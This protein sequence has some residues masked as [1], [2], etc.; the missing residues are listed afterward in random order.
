MTGIGSYT[1]NS[2]GRM[3]GL[4]GF[5]T[6]TTIKSLMDAEKLPL[7]LLQQ[8]RQVVEWRQEAYRDVTTSLRGFK[9]T[10]FDV[11]NPATNMLS[12]TSIRTLSAASSSASYVTAIAASDADLASHT[13]R[14]NKLAT[15]DNALSSSQITK[16]LSGTVSSLNL[17]GKT[18]KATLDGV[19]REITLGDYTGQNIGD[20]LKAAME[21]AFGAGKIAVAYDAGNS[22]GGTI[23]FTTTGGAGKL[24]LSAG[25]VSGLSELGITSGTANRININQSLETISAQLGTAM[26]FNGDYANITINGKAFSFSKS[27]SLASAMSTINADT[28]ANVRIAYDETSD[29]L[30]IKS[31]QLGAGDNI[32]L[33]ESSSTFFS[34]LKIDISGSQTGWAQGQDSEAEIDGQL[35][36]RNS[37]SYSLSN[38]SYT[39][40]KAHQPTDTG[41]TITVSQDSSAAIDK[42][43]GFV[44]KY[45]A[46]LDSLN[47]KISEKYSRDYLPLTDKQK[48]S[49]KEADITTWDKKAKTGLLQNDS[50]LQKVAGDLRRAM[51]DT[52]EGV[53]LTLK[54]IGIASESYQDKGKL[55]IDE[56][57]LRSALQNNPDKVQQLLN[58]V[59]ADVPAYSRT[60]VSTERST[61][62][63]QSGVFQRLSDILDDN[64]STIRDTNGKKGILLEKAGITGDLSAVN[65]TLFTEL[66]G[67][68]DRIT[69]MLDQLTT[70]EDA[71]YKKFSA[72]ETA[73]SKMNQQSSWI[74]S[75]MSG[76]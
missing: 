33:T 61:R 58:G 28:T 53:G 11:V 2:S 19:T 14:V 71:Y 9:S 64:I 68:N 49:M 17:S 4:S 50:I 47:G 40:N 69:V 22:P 52:V 56:N 42:I 46:L 15:A 20:K 60:L 66:K 74:A 37:N 57:K 55:T 29:K 32:Q 76:G 21:T 7:T 1:S 12:E 41:E 30:S 13:V 10:Y 39:F 65:N 6:E 51:S 73:L 26:T 3:T 44:E 54:D 27:T 45:N 8:K 48:E 23:S 34:A 72:L 36:V 70:K 67:Y 16:A 31:K 63:N 59:S 38:V 5:D 43:K 35:V 62:Y 18:I 75:N 24:T 25:N